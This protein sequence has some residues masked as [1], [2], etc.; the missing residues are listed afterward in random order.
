MAIDNTKFYWRTKP[1]DKKLKDTDEG[2]KIVYVDSS[3]G[4]DLYGDGTRQQPYQSLGGA[5]RKTSTRP[6]YI[7]CRGR[8]SENMIDGN[9]T[10]EICGDFYGAAVF[11]GADYYLIYGFRH[12]NMI[13]INTGVGTYDLA[14]QSGS[15]AL[16]GVGCAAH[17][18]SV[19]NA[20]YVF[21]VAGSPV[22]LDR[23]S[24]Y[25]GVIGGNTAVRDLCISRP[26][27]NDEHY[28]SLGGHNSGV[29]LVSGT[30]YGVKIEDRE[31]KPSA[32]NY[33]III[34]STIFSDFAMI[35]NDI[36]I[37][38][39][40]CLFDA[41]CK[42][43]YLPEKRGDMGDVVEFILEGET[44]EEKIESLRSQLE[45]KYIELGVAVANQYYPTFKDCLFSK[46]T[47][48]ELFNDVEN[49]DF[50]L[51]LDSD[52]IKNDYLYYGAFPP[53]LNI[54][55]MNDSTGIPQTWDEHTCDG[56]IKID[57]NVICY[58]EESTSDK[59]SIL[60]KIVKINPS[61]LQING[62]YSLLIRKFSE[63][64]LY[65]NKQECLEKT[66]DG[67]V[68]E[69]KAG[70][71][72]PLGRYLVKGAVVY[73]DLP[74]SANNI[75]VVTEEGTTFVNDY[76]GY[77]SSLLLFTDINIQDV[78]YVRARGMIYTYIKASDGLQSGGVYYNS[79]NKNITY[80]NR[81]IVPN[82]SFVARETGETF[83]CEGDENY[84]IGILFDDTRVPESVWVPAQT[85]GE[86]F[87]G[88]QSG[89]IKVDN[90]GIPVSSGNP[91]SYQASKDG[92]YSDVLKKSILNQKY[93]QF[94]LNIKKYD[95]FS[96]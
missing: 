32:S 71:I 12:S 54:P 28:I 21:G 31:K 2:T 1:T 88:K 86:Y 7:I 93:I 25:Y 43:Y 17:A 58:D 72:L 48:K 40:G 76:E 42:W 47:A 14:V 64:F 55:I 35:A 82:E 41:D 44:T 96:K 26:R 24:L 3:M 75:L 92:G 13:I 80:R 29:T 61:S 38:Y 73:N 69:Y 8:F 10:C 79:G 57:N 90:E 53:A 23:T 89:V 77:E 20:H 22:L 39:E 59:G 81:V 5:Y 15:V 83:V 27:H 65:A 49:C 60:S 18:S 78:V 66:E 16:A 85:Y 19:G 45:S 4:S 68:K 51:K 56:C 37:T 94:A 84:E 36:N 87:V 95:H 70:D 9:H 6:T 30:V 33:K 62:I 46:Q 91:L 63:Y 11:D 34:R 74:I 50:T 67:E 52:G